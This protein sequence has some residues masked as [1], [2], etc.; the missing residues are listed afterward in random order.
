MPSRIRTGIA[1]A[2]FLAAMLA[3]AAALAEPQ[4]GG[5]LRVYH[6]ENP[7]SASM[8]EEASI[9]TVMPFMAVFNN[10]VVY[11]QQA[12]RN[13]PDDLTAELAT[14]WQ[15]SADHR[16]LTFRLREGVTWHDGKPFTSAD[17]KCTWDT[18][19]GWRNAGWRKNP[20]RDWYANLQA[21]ETSGD[22]EVSFLLGR[23]QP[24][25]IA[26]LAS[27]MSPVYPC[28]VDGRTMRQKP[29]GTG[30]FRVVEFRPNNSIE[31]ARNPAYWRPGRPYL[32]AITYRIIRN[33]S[34]RILAFAAGEFDL[35][36][37]SDVTAPLL[38]DLAGQA[39]SAVC[40][41]HSSN[42][43]GQILINRETPPFDNPEIRR[44]VAL[45][46]DHQ[47]YVDILSEGR[48]ALGGALLVPPAGVWGVT[49][50]DLAEAGV[51]GWTG[52]VEQ[53]RAAARRIMQALGYGPDNPLRT[54]VSTRDIATY[55]DPAVI[56]IDQLK[57]IHIEAEL[58]TFDTSLWY[59]HMARP[60]WTLAMNLNGAAIDDPDVV[61]FENYACDS[62]RNYPRYCNRDLE[63]RFTEQSMTL[64]RAARLRLVREIDIQLQRDVA[65]PILYHSGG[66]TCRY[67]HVHGIR[68]AKNSIYNHWRLEDAWMAPR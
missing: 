61:L 44:A 36:F 10:L 2:A 22:F 56:M 49:A 16:R 31:L 18:I 58:Q 17:V 68:L 63:R 39:P 12:E 42:V 55:R 1:G 8:H 11:N 7:A 48:F 15:W 5:T 3:G 46:V 53:R 32:D 59:G 50:Q 47:A 54:K 62:G 27:G 52:S 43:T 23:P 26:F 35:T 64:D 40:E 37:Q 19:A 13:D 33:R 65:R 24:S 4:R 21:V 34:T 41:F 45:A 60:G 30:P 25:F 67:P 38:R 9:A 14:E 51:E 29:I 6:R 28:H 57:A 20:R 66:A